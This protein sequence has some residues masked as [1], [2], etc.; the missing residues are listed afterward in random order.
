L[1]HEKAKAIDAVQRLLT[2]PAV[3]ERV[4]LTVYAW[5]GDARRFRSSRELGSYAGL[6]PSVRQSGEK[7]LLGSITRAGSPELRRILVQAGHVLLFRCRSADAAP[8]KAIAERVQ[9]ARARRKIAVVAAGRHIL[10]LAYYVLRDGTTYDPARLRPPAEQLSIA[11]GADSEQQ[12][13]S[14]PAA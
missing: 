6:V 7:T 12:E 4:A 14:M 8:L 9:T 5:V 10:R 1:L 13:A 11:P 3:G 2:I